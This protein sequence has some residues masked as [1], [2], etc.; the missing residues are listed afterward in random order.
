[1]N[2]FNHLDVPA[3]GICKYCQKGLCIECAV[4]LEYGIACKNH[5][6]EVEMLNYFQLSTLGS[7][8]FAGLVIVLNLIGAFTLLLGSYMDTNGTVIMSLGVFTLSMFF[9]LFSTMLRKHQNERSK[10]A[11]Y[12]TIYLQRKKHG[13]RN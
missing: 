10:M 13:T 6:E 12:Q 3:V 4:N 5:Q 11:I 9:L 7:Y 8:F 2:C 1:M